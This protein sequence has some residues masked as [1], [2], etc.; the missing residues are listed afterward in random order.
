MTPL[1]ASSTSQAVGL[2]DD[3]LIHDLAVDGA[4]LDA[5]RQADDP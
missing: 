5:A 1:A 4:A 2:T 3:L